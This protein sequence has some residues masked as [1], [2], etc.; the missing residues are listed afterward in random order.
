MVETQA[1]AAAREAA[2]AVLQEAERAFN[3][4]APEAARAV[5]RA[6]K[7]CLQRTVPLQQAA[8]PMPAR[9]AEMLTSAPEAGPLLPSGEAAALAARRVCRGAGD[10]QV[11]DAVDVGCV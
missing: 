4:A 1:T 9:D 10:R 8:A 2:G 11:R 5:A 6:E 3:I 7:A